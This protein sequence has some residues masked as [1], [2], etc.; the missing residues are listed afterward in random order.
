[1]LA[2]HTHT[3]TQTMNAYLSK[4]ERA[5]YEQR[6]R[7]IVIQESRDYRLMSKWLVKSYPDVIAEFHAY[8]TRLQKANP[9]RKDLTTSPQFVR[10]MKGEDGT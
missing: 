8:K 5:V 1:M 7:K 4:S 6:R 2:A 9:I 3:H 10:F